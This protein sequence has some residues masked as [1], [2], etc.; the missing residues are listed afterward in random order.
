MKNVCDKP[1]AELQ[2]GRGSWLSTGITLTRQPWVTA[3]L[4]TEQDLPDEARA[5]SW[6]AQK[7]LAWLSSPW[8]TVDMLWSYT[9]ANSPGRKT[10]Q[11]N[12][13]QLFSMRKLK[14]TS[15]R[16]A[17]SADVLVYCFKCLSLKGQACMYLIS[18]GSA[19]ASLELCVFSTAKQRWHPL[20]HLFPEV[21]WA[22][23]SRGGL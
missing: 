4:C 16:Q 11:K 3:Q 23:S 21:R 22:P 9:N 20:C 7:I 18:S 8:A 12:R 13:T 15:Q 10:A 5:L 1:L 2:L 17:T 19:M 6:C 14:F